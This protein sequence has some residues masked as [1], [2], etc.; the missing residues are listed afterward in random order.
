MD[1]IVMWWNPCS[2]PILRRPTIRP[3]LN[4]YHKL[5]RDVVRNR[6]LRNLGCI[7]IDLEL[8]TKQ[9]FPPQNSWPPRQHGGANEIV[10]SEAL[11]EVRGTTKIILW[12][13]CLSLK[14]LHV[15]AFYSYQ[16]TTKRLVKT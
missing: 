6:L 5:H 10:N 7:N 4:E 14:K 8:L 1:S 2:L 12:Y 11:V 3:Q 9:G 15:L 16:K 13:H